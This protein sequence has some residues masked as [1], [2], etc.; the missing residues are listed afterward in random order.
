MREDVRD[1]QPLWGCFLSLVLLPR[2][3]L[4]GGRGPG[5]PPAGGNRQT[6][7]RTLSSTAGLIGKRG[8][9][10]QEKAG[11]SSEEDGEGQAEPLS[12]PG[13]VRG[14]PVAGHEEE[15]QRKSSAL[16]CAGAALS[17][18]VGATPSSVG[19]ASRLP[20]WIVNR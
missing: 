10:P 7:G 6:R 19:E 16:G 9:H 20:G 15:P 17:A 13:S 12:L 3:S 5:A 14:K 1:L 4:T 2:V 8:K 11:D 18:G